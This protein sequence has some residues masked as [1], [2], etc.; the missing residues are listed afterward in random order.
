MKTDH[1]VRMG[2]VEV[3]RERYLDQLER[4]LTKPSDIGNWHAFNWKYEE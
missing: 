4:A 3:D 2:A 1:L